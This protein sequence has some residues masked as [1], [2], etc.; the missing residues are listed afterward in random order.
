MNV[1]CI[2]ALN[3][4]NQFGT[5]HEGPCGH[6][7]DSAL[8]VDVR[9]DSTATQPSRQVAQLAMLNQLCIHAGLPSPL[10]QGNSDP[11]WPCMMIK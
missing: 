3:Q 8:H 4:S 5:R 11:A 6:V 9:R 1:F 10:G 2:M 7:H